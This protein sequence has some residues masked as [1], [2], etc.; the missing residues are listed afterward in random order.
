VNTPRT[1]PATI[2]RTGFFL[3]LTLLLTA[4]QGRGDDPANV[5]PVFPPPP[6]TSAGG[7]P[8][9][10]PRV[11]LLHPEGDPDDLPN[12][13]LVVYN[14]NDP[15]SKALAEYYASKRDIADER[16]L[17]LACSTAEEISRAEYD[18]TLR[19]PILAYLYQKNWM[20]RRTVTLQIAGQA[21]Q[22]Y[23]ADFNNIWAIVLMRG[24][25]LKI[26]N[27]PTTPGSMEKDVQLASNAAAVDSELSLLPI[28]G[29]P[30]GGFVPNP[31][32]DAYMSGT[33][34]AGPEVAT[35]IIFVTR[36]DGPTPADVRRMID[37]SLWAERNRLAGLAVI[38]SRGITDAS[39]G[40]TLGD[41]WLRSARS[42]LANEGWAIEFDQKPEPLPATDPCNHVAL[43]LGWYADNASGPW[44][45][46][47]DRFEPGAIA[48]HLHSYSA[49]SVRST[50][51]FW[52]GPLIAHGADA[53]MGCVYE[54]YLG[55]TPHLDIFTKRLLMGQTFAE[56]AYASQKGLSWMVTV[57]GDP[58]Y[59]P[60]ARPIDSVLTQMGAHRSPHND[61]LY[62]Q[63]I[64]QAIL[65]HRFTPDT[66]TLLSHIAAPGAS[67][68]SYEGLGDLLVQL[69]NPSSDAAT[70]K[71]Y[72]EALALDPQP[73]DQIRVGLK[74]AQYDLEHGNEDD[75][76]AVLRQL[77]QLHPQ[78]AAR[79]GL[80]K[81]LGPT[82]ASAPSP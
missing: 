14:S 65:A 70:E 57:V 18:T 11:N 9:L 69:N 13:L 55:L 24:V 43:Y 73:I 48:Y 35:K 23:A 5:S 1:D 37:D 53:T 28:S 2:L 4:G 72:Q 63:Y 60:F 56:A 22:V 82:P 34:R 46:P 47:P 74:L 19:E 38:D 31:F 10:P 59:R 71:A 77:W 20:A 26:A 36:L 30:L 49:S 80:A 3:F 15:D 25:P 58:L 40:Y 52:V 32:F 78:D 39:S 64:R 42:M 45:T 21:L 8:M 50:T 7:A 44:I 79:F 61:W 12:H 81:P 41:S 6:G 29:L 16:V 33:V 76:Q 75:V 51:Q 66:A 27:D 54:P 17:G 62:L 68:V 67:G